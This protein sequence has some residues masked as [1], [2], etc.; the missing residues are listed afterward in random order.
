MVPF[1]ALLQSDEGVSS[2]MGCEVEVVQ[3]RRDWG[4]LSLREAL[5]ELWSYLLNL[6]QSQHYRHFTEII[7][8]NKNNTCKIQFN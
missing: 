1:V 2:A 3:V 8:N 6:L 4:D 7:I 5:L